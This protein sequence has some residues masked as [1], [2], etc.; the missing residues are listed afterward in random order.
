ML[1]IKIIIQDGGVEIANDVLMWCR[2]ILLLQRRQV[3]GIYILCLAS[4]TTELCFRALHLGT[5]IS[6]WRNFAMFV[7]APPFLSSEYL[8]IVMEWVRNECSRARRCQTRLSISAR[9]PSHFRLATSTW[10]CELEYKLVKGGRVA[11]FKFLDRHVDD[12]V[13]MAFWNGESVAR[14]WNSRAASALHEDTIGEMSCERVA[15][16]VCGNKHSGI[17]GQ[18]RAVLLGMDCS[19]ESNW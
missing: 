9:I 16:T 13:R 7:T 10:P 2:I 15:D 14:I 11:A 5:N 8:S 1:R 19:I 4:N 3:R 18:A 6:R 12:E 17:A